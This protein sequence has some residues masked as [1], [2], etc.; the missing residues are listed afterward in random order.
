MGD[1]IYFQL[2]D[3]D[4]IS[5][6]ALVRAFRNILGVLEDLDASVSQ[7]PRGTVDWEVAVLRKASP[8]ILG[9]V[10]HPKRRVEGAG[11]RRFLTTGRD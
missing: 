4:E 10:G 3:R 7:D 1:V 2:G 11:P 6:K 5:M 9:L 8:P